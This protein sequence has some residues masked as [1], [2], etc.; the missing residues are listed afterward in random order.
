ME[1]TNLWFCYPRLLDGFSRK[2][3]WLNVSTSN[4]NP[5]IIANFFLNAIDIHGICPK[6]LRMDKGTENIYCEDLQYFLT[7]EEGSYIYGPST[8]NQ[9]IEAFWSRLKKLKLGWWIEFFSMMVRDRPFKSEC[10]VHQEVLIFCF[11]PVLQ[12]ELN[13]FVK[14]WNTRFIRQSSSAPGGRPDILFS[15]PETIG[16]TKQGIP[17][18]DRDVSIARNILGIETHPVYMN[19]DLHELLLCYCGIHGHSV[20]C[21]AESAFDLFVI[22]IQDL[23]RDGIL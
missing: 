16:Y 1:M 21:D 9:R 10:E 20:P 2:L 22:L 5:I 12:A 23:R 14:T 6:T 15:L 19:S 11:M 3:M 8:R 17:I 18:C 13:L 7:G 4:S